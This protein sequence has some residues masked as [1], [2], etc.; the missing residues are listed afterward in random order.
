MYSNM[1]CCSSKHHKQWCWIV[2]LVGMRQQLLAT[3]GLH[4]QAVHTCLQ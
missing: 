1:C 2:V 3:K 4:A